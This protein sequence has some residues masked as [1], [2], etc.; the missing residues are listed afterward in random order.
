[1]IENFWGNPKVAGFRTAAIGGVRQEV[2][3]HGKRYYR[4]QLWSFPPFPLVSPGRKVS[5]V[6][7]QRLGSRAAVGVIGA[8]P[9]GAGVPSQLPLVVVSDGVSD[10]VSSLA[11]ATSSCHDRVWCAPIPA[12]PTSLDV[13]FQLPFSPESSQVTSTVMREKWDESG[14]KDRRSCLSE[15]SLGTTETAPKGATAKHEARA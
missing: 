11:C 2:P 10:V 8:F 13:G 3:V 9:S 6:T 15:I 5:W 14:W 12:A 1:M 7:P 4:V